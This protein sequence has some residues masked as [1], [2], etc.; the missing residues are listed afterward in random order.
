[1]TEFKHKSIEVPF[2]DQT[3]KNFEKW[4]KLIRE[5]QADLD[6]EVIREASDKLWS[7]GTIPGDGIDFIKGKKK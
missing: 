5:K 6:K 4:E 1:M 7:K 3:H 2:L